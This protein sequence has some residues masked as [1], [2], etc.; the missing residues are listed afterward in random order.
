MFFADFSAVLPESKG[1]GNANIADLRR[2]GGLTQEELA[3]DVGVSTWYVQSVERGVNFP[4]LPVLEKLK[5]ALKSSW[6]SLFDG[7]EE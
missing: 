5:K 2:K 7:V 3:E 4:S 6:G 1:V